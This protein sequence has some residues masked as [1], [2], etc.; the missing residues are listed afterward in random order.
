MSTIIGIKNAYEIISKLE[1]KVTF[2]DLMKRVNE[3]LRFLLF[4]KTS[5]KISSSPSSFIF[6]RITLS[7]FALS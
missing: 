5:L 3:S 4:N 2:V 1:F 6:D 7:V